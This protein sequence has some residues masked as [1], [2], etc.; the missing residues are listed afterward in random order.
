[1]SFTK[2]RRAW[3]GC[4][5]VMCVMC[6]VTSVAC[7]S[8][9]STSTSTPQPGSAIGP[10]AAQTIGAMGGTVTSADG[11]LTVA[12]PPGALGTDLKITVQEITAP[13][14]GAIGK[15]YEIGPTGTQFE[16]PV[17]LSFKYAPAE[18][19]ATAAADLEVATIAFGAWSPLP[20]DT[21]D[22]SAQIASGTTMHLSPY[23]LIA[24]SHGASDEAGTGGDSG[25]GD[26]TVDDGGDAGIT[27]AA[28]DSA[29]AS[30]G[31]SSCKPQASQVG[32]CLNHPTFCTMYPGTV[33]GACTT[34]DGGQGYVVQCCS[35]D[36]G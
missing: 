31:A 2:K 11:A 23:G 26:A 19:G 5:F 12:V 15:T 24:K 33:A 10:V 28:A 1:M 3:A 22:V 30:D 21:V 6:V 27:D 34:N 25:G 35:A 32:S 16:M 9:T 36:G 17:T 7:S 18:L 29:D 14:P 4:A 8:S 13:A 20:G